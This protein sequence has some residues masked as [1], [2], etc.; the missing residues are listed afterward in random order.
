MIKEIDRDSMNIIMA[1][2]KIVKNVMEGPWRYT[3]ALICSF[4]VHSI[5]YFYY[6][7]EYDDVKDIAVQFELVGG[8]DEQPLA[9]DAA[10]PR[11]ALEDQNKNADDD[12][13]DEPPMDEEQGLIVGD[14]DLLVDTEPLQSLK[15]SDSEENK[16]TDTSTAVIDDTNTEISTD[17]DSTTDS[18]VIDSDSAVHLASKDTETDSHH[19]L[20]SDSDTESIQLA[21]SG[22][23]DSDSSTDNGGNIDGNVRNSAAEDGICLH[24]VFAYGKEN[25][26]WLLWL[27]MKAFDKTQYAQGLAGVLESFYLYDEM[28]SATEIKPL[29]ELEGALISADHFAEFDTYQVVTTY[30]IGQDIL[31]SRLQKNHGTNPKFSLKQTPQGLSGVLQ[32]GYRWDMVGS[33]RVMVAS[34]AKKGQMNSHWPQT[35]TCMQPRQ[36]F[37]GDSSAHFRTLVR[38]KMG[39]SKQG[40]RWPVMLLATRDPFAVGLHKNPSLVKMFQWAIVKG[41]FSDPIQLQGE[42]KFKGTSADMKKVEY[43]V[44]YL[45]TKAEYLTYLG[46]GNIA[47]KIEYKIEG[48]T[49]Y[50]TIPMTQKQ[51]KVGLFVLQRYSKMLNSRF[52]PNAK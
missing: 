23:L 36:P 43:M 37:T 51:V 40:E 44:K 20:D 15:D 48:T 41:Y 1:I 5:I 18:A 28:V 17:S 22:T 50:F 2:K 47:E 42:A 27:S 29:T 16:I 9:P 8:L 39:P 12:L 6:A 10:G 30:N 46:L 32:G 14:S 25:P 52:T 45:L 4:L 21:Q 26:T 19:N 49:L 31:S 13:S 38:S 7:P 33:G 34:D 35:V 24:D 3:A 11:D